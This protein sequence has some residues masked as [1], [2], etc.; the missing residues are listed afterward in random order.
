M[1]SDFWL[2]PE[3]GKRFKEKP[4]SYSFQFF[5]ATKDEAKAQ[6][7][8]E[9]D[10]VVAAQPVHAQDR[11]AAIASAHA[12]I[13]LV[14]LDADKGLQVAVHGS[15]SYAWTS[16]ETDASTVPLHGG[17]VGVSVYQTAKTA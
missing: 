9:F 15:V 17:S 8:K 16:P 6:L 5:A 13:D 1:W 12:F 2:A 11:A 7:E 10:N 3:Y 4:M 14:T